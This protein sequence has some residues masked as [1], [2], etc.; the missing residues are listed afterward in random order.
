MWGDYLW[1]VVIGGIASFISS[2]GIGAN[3]VANAFATSV[4]SKTITLTQACLI[5]AIFEF[6]GAVALGGEVSKAIAGGIAKLDYFDREPEVLMYGMM[7]ALIAA[8]FWVILASYLELAVS[9]THS[10]VGAVIGFS[11]CFGGFDAVVWFR[12]KPDFPY[13]EGVVMIVASWFLSPICAAICTAALFLTVRTLVL[14]RKNSVK[15]SY[16]A[17]PAVVLLAVFVNALFVITKGMSKVVSWPASQAVWISAVIAV[18]ASILSVVLLIPYIKWRV[19]KDEEEAANVA[20]LP[21]ASEDKDVE[22][23]GMDEAPRT[24]W[25]GMLDKAHAFSTKGLKVDIHKAVEDDAQVAALHANAEVFDSGAENTFKYVQ[26]FT[27]CCVSFA[28]GANDVANAVGPFTTIYYVYNN[29]YIRSSVDMPIWILVMGGVGIVLGLATYGYNVMRA[30]GVKLVTL[31][32]SR[33]FCIELATALVLSVGSRFG[34][35]LSST[36]VQVG[37]TFTMGL[38]EGTGG[39]NFKLMGKMVL[40]WIFTLVCAGT[41]CGALFSQG[42]YAPSIQ[43]GRHIQD[44]EIGV[45]EFALD[46]YTL[47]N[48]TLYETC[49]VTPTPVNGSSYNQTCLANNSGL[50]KT[51]QSQYK[52]CKSYYNKVEGKVMTIQTVGPDQMLGCM[53]DAEALYRNYTDFS[54]TP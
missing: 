29:R 13:A 28:H 21:S 17:L 5:A 30:L 26:V 37:G 6:T 7:C 24:G 38:L 19:R 27:A 35:P 44:Y 39:S 43:M 16:W 46:T 12:K 33:G 25:R 20:S 48:N 11:L 4:G 8:G 41:V 22:L 36:H 52:T 9:T 49:T 34:L 54:I 32:P 14:R 10:I 47:M 50:S 3:D 53:N 40:G 42:A 1:I 2:Y 23:A 45:Q 31:T 18:G 51:I 15:L